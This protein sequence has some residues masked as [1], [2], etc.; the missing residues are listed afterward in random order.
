M[1]DNIKNLEEQ[2]NKNIIS[3][4]NIT[5]KNIENTYEINTSKIISNT[6]NKRI[7]LESNNKSIIIYIS[8]LKSH[9][10]KWI[11]SI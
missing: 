8:N 2:T 7:K 4:A 9:R 1:L 10:K 3:Y 11:I 5:K 6:I